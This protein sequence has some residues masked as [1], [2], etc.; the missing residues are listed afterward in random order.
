MAWTG[1]PA[2]PDP[3]PDLRDAAS[4]WRSAIALDHLRELVETMP[5]PRSRIHAP[6]AMAAADAFILDGWRTSGWTVD[7]QELRLENVQGQLDYA[8]SDSPGSPPKSAHVYP[9]LD[10]VNLVGVLPG[11]V[12]EAIVVV[13]H[14]DTV[15]GSPGAD[16]NGAGVVALLELSRLLAGRTFHRSVVLAAPDLEEVG[17]IGSGALVP[18]LKERYQLRGAIVFDAIAYMDRAPRTQVVP[19]GLEWLYRGQAARLRAR[20]YAGDSL[21]AIYRDAS[22]QLVETWA[23]CLAAAIG[24]ERV[25]LLRDPADL[26]VVGR[27]AR[28]LPV[29]RNFSRSD[30]V[31]FWEGGVPAIHV[32]D[33][34]N[35]RNPNYHQPS[36]TAETLDY[37]SL[38]GIVAA[39]ALAVERLAGEPTGSRVGPRPIPG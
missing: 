14:H 7:R 23:Q 24:R 9:R 27:I 17:L 37:D 6:D 26:P 13:A 30:H 4:R 2:Y 33:T 36:D 15:R 10:G 11:E 32:S 12:R 22:R 16:D 29:V 8:R 5:G 21:V 31:S 3:S 38:A 28:I 25:L 19:R 20:D 34:G 39:T 1:E 18:W 35:F